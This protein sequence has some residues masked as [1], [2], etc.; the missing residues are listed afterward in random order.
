MPQG[1]YDI[2]RIDAEHYIVKRISTVYI[3][4]ILMYPDAALFS[5]DTL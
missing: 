1:I 5:F 3:L 2:Q 4:F